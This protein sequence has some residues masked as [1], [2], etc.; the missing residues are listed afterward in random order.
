MPSKRSKNELKKERRRYSF[1]IFVHENIPFE[2]I[3]R[4]N[5][6]TAY[7]LRLNQLSKQ[8]NSISTNS[9]TQQLSEYINGCK[10][11]EPITP[12]IPSPQIEVA[13]AQ[14]GVF[15]NNNLKVRGENLTQDVTVNELAFP[16]DNVD[17]VDNVDNMGYIY[18][19]EIEYP[20][21][22]EIRD[23]EG[24]PY[25][26]IQNMQNIYGEEEKVDTDASRLKGVGDVE[27]LT[28]TLLSEHVVPCIVQNTQNIPPIHNIHNGEENEADELEKFVLIENEILINENNTQFLLAPNNYTRNEESLERFR[29]P[30]STSQIS[31]G[32]LTQTVIPN[33]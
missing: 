4:S 10:S 32:F 28:P 31:G 25:T 5:E 13:S 3:S 29:S 30:K 24:I 1:E 33:T 8:L 12:N 14:E 6:T 16:L 2:E 7:D 11:G 23:A 18:E 26:N 19:E 22:K 27:P 17:N 20:P 9:K 15:I 21:E